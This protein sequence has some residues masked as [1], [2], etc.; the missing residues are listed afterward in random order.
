MKEMEK[1]R[2]LVHR[3]PDY[4]KSIFAILAFGLIFGWLTYIIIYKDLALFSPQ[5]PLSIGLI[6]Y[7]VPAI[8]YGLLTRLFLHGFKKRRAYLL[9]LFNETLLFVGV[10][11]LLAV[12]RE[13]LI[14]FIWWW[15]GLIY[16]FNVLGLLGILGSQGKIKSLLYP[17]IYPA[18]VLPSLFSIYGIYIISKEALLLRSSLLLG[19]GLILLLAVYLIGYLF[20]FPLQKSERVPLLDLVSSFFTKQSMNLDFL[21]TEA[22]SL[23]QGLKIKRKS[24]GK[25]QA[26][27]AIPWLHP[28]PIRSLGGGFLSTAIIEGLDQGFFWHVPSSHNYDPTNLD[29]LNQL[30]SKINSEGETKSK[31]TKMMAV[32]GHGASVNQ[33]TAGKDNE[34]LREGEWQLHGQ[35]LDD[36][37]LITLDLPDQDDYDLAIFKNIRDRLDEK[38]IFVDSH[39]HTDSIYNV[40]QFSSARAEAMGKATAQLV[41]KLKQEEAHEFKAGVALAEEMM[42]LTF[43]VKDEHDLYL[44][45]NCNGL[46]EELQQDLSK[47][48]QGYDLDNALVLTT[49]AHT[50]IKLPSDTFSPAKIRQVI[51]NSLSKFKA[52]IE[53]VESELK[54]IRILGGNY[55]SVE[56]STSI[57][58][59]LFILFLLILYLTSLFLI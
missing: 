41:E 34:P 42:G 30:K 46:T 39:N 51:D 3:A 25:E 36:L 18:L 44:T 24:D 56:S 22:N 37:Y 14:N 32:R 45:L 21:G 40:M 17:L 19:L 1:F 48:L 27:V 10:V 59:H 58:S 6:V 38:I 29:F 23:L 11:L 28:G 9:S 7:M 31:M 26:K 54:G 4:K 35:R 43:K 13:H 55:R 2:R 52:N 49:D 57:L 53:Y 15:M 5:R 20:N 33:I 50:S 47:I 12:S 8:I 16:S